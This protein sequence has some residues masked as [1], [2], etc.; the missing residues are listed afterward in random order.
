MKDE[1]AGFIIHHS[2]FIPC[3]MPTTIIGPTAEPYPSVAVPAIVQTKSAW[4]DDWETQPELT[5]VRASAATA[6]HDLPS[7]EF[8]HRYGTLKHPWEKTAKA[9]PP[10]DFSG[11]WVRVLFGG[12]QGMQEAWIGRFSGEGR[13]VY[14]EAGGLQKWQ[15]LGPQDILR[16]RHVSSS[17]WLGKPPGA[18]APIMQRI[19]WLPGLN[20]R[21]GRPGRARGAHLG[22]GRSGNMSANV[23]P[24]G[25]SYCYG[26]T[27]GEKEWTYAIYLDYDLIHGHATLSLQETAY[28]YTV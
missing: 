22:I 18:G 8:H 6:A 23:A 19:G 20:E 1:L 7:A 13:D 17:Y 16:K 27:D 3:V 10:A 14:G 21:D 12:D 24:D 15:A 25:K 4:T 26:D 2:S 9:R 5:F 28:P 11:Q